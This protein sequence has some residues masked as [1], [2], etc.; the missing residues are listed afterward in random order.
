MMIP[1]LDTMM[2]NRKDLSSEFDPMV[3]TCQ[4]PCTWCRH[5]EKA[6]LSRQ[7][8]NFVLHFLLVSLRCIWLFGDFWRKHDG[9]SL[10]VFEHERNLEPTVNKK[11]P[12]VLSFFVGV[13]VVATIHFFC[14]LLLPA[15]FPNHPVSAG[16]DTS[17][18]YPV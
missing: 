3:I 15:V 6:A 13:F 2:R 5:D 16:H 4:H 11:P 10:L 14:H 17:S 7:P 12:A 18:K 1:I 8:Y 9:V